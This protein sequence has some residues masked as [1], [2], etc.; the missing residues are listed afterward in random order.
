[1]LTQN[2]S[3]FKMKSQFIVATKRNEF[4]CI[5]TRAKEKKTIPHSEDIERR[6]SSAIFFFHQYLCLSDTQ[7]KIYTIFSLRKFY[8][9]FDLI[10]ILPCFC[11]WLPKKKMKEKMESFSK[12]IM[13]ICYTTV[14]TSCCMSMSFILYSSNFSVRKM[15]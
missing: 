5:N 10:L 3:Q 8:F 13:T 9:D 1:M 2:Q 7:H 6:K 11:V 14:C 12:P 15:C 4:F